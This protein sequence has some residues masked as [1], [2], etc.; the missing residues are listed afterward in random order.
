LF[1]KLRSAISSLTDSISKSSLSEKDLDSLLWRFELGL[2]ESDVSENVAKDLATKVKGRLL[3]SKLDQGSDAENMLK[4]HL[5]KEI[6]GVF[7]I[8]GSVD[9]Q[10]LVRSKKM[11]HEPFTI[12]FLGVNGTGKTTTLA[13]IAYLFKEQGFSVVLASGDTHRAGAIE[14]LSTHAERLNLKFVSQRY[15]ADPAAVG[16]DAIAFARNH[17][18]DVVLLDT[19]GRMQ[20]SRNLMD[21]VTKIV[22]VVEP[23]LKIFVG[24]SLTGNDAISQA[25]E[26][27]ASTEFDAAILTKVD[28]D[29]KGGAALSIA[30]IAKKP[31]IYF[32]VGQEY[33]D[34]I[35]FEASAFINSLFSPRHEVAG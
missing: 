22:R 26:F 29:A 5:M 11:T 31:I 23:D 33:D 3:E 21:E 27:F 34:L 16:R 4:D 14:Q 24:D 15:G 19:A 12:M 9:I 25:T 8:A 10:S 30:Y 18:V 17:H 20:T 2:L 32:G 13:K 1:E 7:D 35:A 28:A 6:K